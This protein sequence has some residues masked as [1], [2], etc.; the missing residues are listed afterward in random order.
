[1]IEIVKFNGKNSLV[2]LNNISSID[3]VS[4]ED[5]KEGSIKT[6]IKMAN[7]DTYKCSFEYEDFKVQI[8]SYLQ[9]K[10]FE[11]DSDELISM[12]EEND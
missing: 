6:I 7:G 11:Q 9:I 5:M 2:F 3:D 8:L 10:E 1:M 4:N 12:E